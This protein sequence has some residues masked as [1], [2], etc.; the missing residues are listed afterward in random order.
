VRSEF[1]TARV[2]DNGD[3]T[4]CGRRSLRANRCA[5]CLHDEVARLLREIGEHETEVRKRRARIAE[6][7]TE[8]GTTARP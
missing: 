5:D 2:W 7:S 8:S 6:L 3:M 1:C 4:D